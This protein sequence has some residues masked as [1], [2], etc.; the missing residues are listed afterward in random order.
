MNTEETRINLIFD[1]GKG[2]VPLHSREAVS[3]ERYGKLPVPTRRGYRFAGWYFGERRVEAEDVM[4]SDADIRLYARWEREH[5]RERTKSSMFRRQK[6]ALIVLCAVAVL[7]VISLVVVLDLVS[8]Y[9]LTDT[10]LVNGVEYSDTYTIKRQD[11]VYKLFDKNGVLME[12]NGQQDNVFIAANSGNQYQIDSETGDYQ[13]I[14]VVD[15]EDYEVVPGTMLMMYPQIKSANVY[16]IEVK[17]SDGTTYRF[18][19][20]GD[21]VYIDGFKESR[22]EYDKDLYAMLCSA[23]GYTM[24]SMK[25]DSKSETSSVPKLED[26]TIDYAVYGLDQPQATFTISAIKDKDAKVYEADESRTYTVYVGQKTLSDSGYYVKLANT[27][28]VYILSSSY[29]E[30]TVM[31]PIEQLVTARAVFPVSVSQHSMAQKFYLTYLTEWLGDETVS[32]NPIVAFDYEEMEYRENTIQ[33]NYPYICNSDLLTGMD[34][35]R[36]NDSNASTALGLLMNIECLACKKIGLDAESLKEYGLTENVYYLTYMTKTGETSENGKELY[37]TNQILIGQKT[38]NDTYYIA[39]IPYDMIVEVDQYYLSFLEWDSVDWYNQYFMSS[40]IAYTQEVHFQFGDEQYDFIL[41]NRF[42][43]A[44]Y[45]TRT[46]QESE[47]QMVRIDLTT[48]TVFGKETTDGGK[49]YYYKDKNGFE[50]QIA[51]ILDFDTIEYV[52]YETAAKNLTL[53]NILYIE[54]LYYYTDSNGKTVRVVPDYINS[55]VEEREDGY[56]Y[57]FTSNGKTMEKKVS[58]TTGD[59]IYRYK[60]GISTTLEIG[61]NNLQILCKQY[62]NGEGDQKELLDYR[63]DHVYIDDSGIQQTESY[64]GT[65]NFRKFY[66]SLVECSLQGDVDRSEFKKAMG[67]SVEEYLAS[68]HADPQAVIT[69]YAEDYASLLNHSVQYDEKGNAIRVH[70]TNITRNLVFRFYA[71]TE[72]K[73]LVTVE[74]LE[75][76]ENGNWVSTTDTPVGRFYVDSSVLNTFRSEIQSVLSGELI[77]N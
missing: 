74:L 45:L 36:I 73:S 23:C 63:K 19:N 11:G 34:G 77:Q 44:Y 21:G 14:A 57:L 56:Y 70:E 27:N 61:S 53:K 76:D 46:S 65:D 1:A 16:S 48:G 15:T 22:L 52:S 38:E 62:Q 71:Y 43:Y 28:T 40:N 4:D 30:K 12:T 33:A 32:G 42:S 31:Q 68:D 7:L 69:F 64:T 8:M 2:Q 51:V 59:L 67:M 18:L 37:A 24:T 60:E 17:H 49:K 58:K 54:D 10:Y 20:T 72:W 29:L 35:Y 47:I 13:L 66:K 41:D 25:L 39:S 6:T 9:S 26:G 3:G 5:A 50:Y 75:Q 55:T